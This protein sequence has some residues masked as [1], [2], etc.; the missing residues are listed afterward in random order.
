VEQIYKMKLHEEIMIVDGSKIMKVPGGW[1]Y[2]QFELNQP[3]AGDNGWN[4][5]FTTTSVFVPFNDEFQTAKKIEMERKFSW[6]ELRD[7]V[8]KWWSEH[9]YDTISLSDGDEDNV[10]DR[11]PEFVTIAKCDDV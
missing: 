4:E 7:A 11:D 2:T 3:P 5:T 9:E 6:E 8:L 1:I 10:F